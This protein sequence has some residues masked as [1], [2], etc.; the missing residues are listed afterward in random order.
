MLNNIKIT[1][2]NLIHQAGL[3]NSPKIF[4]LLSSWPTLAVEYYIACVN[5]SDDQAYKAT[6]ATIQ[7]EITSCVN[8]PATNA[9][10]KELKALIA[11]WI[12]KAHELSGGVGPLPS[13]SPPTSSTPD[14][15]SAA[16]TTSPP[17]GQQPSTLRR[18]VVNAPTNI[19]Y[20]N[21]PGPSNNSASANT[22]GNSSSQGPANIPGASF[23]SA[24]YTPNTSY[25]S[26]TPYQTNNTNTAGAPYT[27]TPSAVTNASPAQPSVTGQ[28]TADIEDVFLTFK[29]IVA[30]I[31]PAHHSSAALSALDARSEGCTYIYKKI[32]VAGN[33]RKFR[34]RCERL[35]DDEMYQGTHF[36]EKEV[37]VDIEH[38]LKQARSQPT[39]AEVE[40][41]Y[42]ERIKA[43]VDEVTLAGKIKGPIR[44]FRQFAEKMARKLAR[45]M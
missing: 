18:R 23:S 12:Q 40:T 27:G 39:Y 5:I 1:I 25:T 24:A 38:E 45:K 10:L 44:H 2:D 26:S 9:A 14:I 41:A 30:L 20:T 29:D 11:P 31:P 19:S 15:V 3:T 16:Q 42:V 4:K 21:N 22:T 28:A 8:Q 7:K 35:T 43:K 6:S 34:K 32:H 33:S 37:L 17:S 36:V 13:N